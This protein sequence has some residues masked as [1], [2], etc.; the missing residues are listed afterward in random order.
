M[1][2]ASDN[3]TRYGPVGTLSVGEGG[4][5]LVK[6]LLNRTYDISIRRS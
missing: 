6:Q 4:P 5:E 3:H 1:I 2:L